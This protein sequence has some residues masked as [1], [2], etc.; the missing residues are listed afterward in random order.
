[1]LILPKIIIGVATPTHG[2]NLFSAE[3]LELTKHKDASWGTHSRDSASQG[4]HD[5]QMREAFTSFGGLWTR[6]RVALS[7]SVRTCGLQVERDGKMDQTPAKP[8]GSYI[9]AGY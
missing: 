2:S 7:H 5:S 3:T 8:G 1:M 4:P 6:L 9:Y